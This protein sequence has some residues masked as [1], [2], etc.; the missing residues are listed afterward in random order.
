MVDDWQG[1]A[2]ARRYWSC[3]R[4]AREEG[5]LRF[6]EVMLATYLE[7]LDLMRRLGPARVV[8][9]DGAT[10]EV[11]AELPAAAPASRLKDALRLCA[12]ERLPVEPAGTLVPAGDAR[13]GR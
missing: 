7:V 10:V 13:L 4:R 5:V 9:R 1:K 6:T 12:D 2:S 3:W 11:E 8:R